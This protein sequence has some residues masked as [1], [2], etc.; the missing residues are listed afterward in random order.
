LGAR[1]AHIG[2]DELQQQFGTGATKKSIV[3]T[4]EQYNRFDQTNS[5]AASRVRASK[6]IKHIQSVD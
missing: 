6:F 1:G 3:S 2:R 5:R 4:T